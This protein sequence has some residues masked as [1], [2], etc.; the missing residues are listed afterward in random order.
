M[1][2]TLKILEGDISFECNVEVKLEGNNKTSK[3]RKIEKETGIKKPL[4]DL[5]SGLKFDHE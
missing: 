4:K 3:K 1:L 2:R 5:E